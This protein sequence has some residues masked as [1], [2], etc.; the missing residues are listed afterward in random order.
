MKKSQALKLTLG[1][2][3]GLV[4]FG[5]PVQQASAQLSLRAVNNTSRPPPFTNTRAQYWQM[6]T[7]DQYG[8]QYLGWNGMAGTIPRIT[9][10]TAMLGGSGSVGGVGGYGG[11]GG[12]Y[13][14]IGGGI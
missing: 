13:G 8:A 1:A 3:L 4:V 10:Y 11:V 9:P 12:G 2:A 6:T 14:G 7:G 5:T